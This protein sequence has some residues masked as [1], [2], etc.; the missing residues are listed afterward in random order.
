MMEEWWNTYNLGWVQLIK[1]V[2]Y[3]V[4]ATNNEVRYTRD[5]EIKE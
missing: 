3:A 1:K 2:K 5:T 4:E